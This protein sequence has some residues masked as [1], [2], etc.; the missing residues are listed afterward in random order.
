MFL[1]YSQ[2]LHLS[3][4]LA[5]EKHPSLSLILVNYRRKKFYN[6]GPRLSSETDQTNVLV[7]P[8]GATTFSIITLSQMDATIILM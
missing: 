6:I 1:P 4:R 8:Q 7:P 2:I 5:M 3:E